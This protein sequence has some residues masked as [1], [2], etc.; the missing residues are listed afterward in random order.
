MN[1][2][3][4]IKNIRFGLRD[5]IVKNNLKSLVLGISGGIDST[6]CAVLAK[7]VCDELNISLIGRSLPSSTN[8]K[9]ENNRAKLIG[10]RFC[11][12]FKEVN[13][14]KTF[15]TIFDIC[16]D[17]HDVLPP[18]SK[19]AILNG[20]MKARI[21]MILLYDLA[22]ANDGLVLSTDNY[23][24]YLLGFWT[25]HG[26]VGDFGMIQSFWK[27]EVYNM[28]EWIRDNKFQDFGDMIFKE[29]E[30][31]SKVLNA[32][33]TDGNGITNTDLD[34]IMPEWKGT[35][36]DGYKEI[37]KILINFLNSG[38]GDLDDPVI[39]RYLKTDFKRNN[40]YNLS[41]KRENFL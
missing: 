40:P 20:N 34:Q 22:G 10:E 4:L 13:I 32:D 37:D 27:T 1:Y 25:L 33:A 24:E 11:T 19:D 29:K 30:I 9:D 16:D 6:L 38:S 35:S 5:Y 28:V 8:N 12:E 18:E 7:P 17:N 26:D 15:Y 31:L 23:T 39:H 41:F 2:Q 21:R 3:A 36:R 14:N